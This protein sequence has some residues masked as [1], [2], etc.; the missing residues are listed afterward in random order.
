MHTQKSD[1][2]YKSKKSI[3]KILVLS[4]K[5]QFCIRKNQIY[6]INPDFAYAF[7]DFATVFVFYGFMFFFKIDFYDIF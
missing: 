2:C 3:R 1:L 5:F 6:N 7:Y 4:Y